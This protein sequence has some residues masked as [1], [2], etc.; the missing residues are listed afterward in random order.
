MLF[1]H[2][3]GS[4]VRNEENQLSWAA[5]IEILHVASLVHDDI[6]DDSAKRRGI[7]TTHTLYGK[8]RATYSGNYLIG[9]A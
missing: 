7:D 8:K 4:K 6:L 3:L 1:Y 9:R 5:V 2:H